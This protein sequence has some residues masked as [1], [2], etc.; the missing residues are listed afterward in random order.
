VRRRNLNSFTAS[1][2]GR[3]DRVQ[4]STE[5]QSRPCLKHTCSAMRM[6]SQVMY[7]DDNDTQ[8]NQDDPRDE[9]RPSAWQEKREQCRADEHSRGQ[10][11]GFHQRQVVRRAM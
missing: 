3:A 5:T 11:E 9:K 10:N 2:A 4:V 1:Q 6:S 8:N 7:H